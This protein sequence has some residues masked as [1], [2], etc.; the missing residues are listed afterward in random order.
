MKSTSDTP[1]TNEQMLYVNNP[2]GRDFRVVSVSF[3]RELETELVAMTKERDEFRAECDGMANLIWEHPTAPCDQDSTLKSITRVEV[4][5]K[6]CDAL[7]A[8][9]KIK[10][11]AL[12]FAT[13]RHLD[14]LVLIG[15]LRSE[16]ASLKGNASVALFNSERTYKDALRS[17]LA[18]FQQP[19]HQEQD[20]T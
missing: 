2:H 10:L 6:E 3:A 7:R 16:L 14:Q 20:I 8:E 19:T 4:L 9:L 17:E 13:G 12:T 18:Q 1:R 15:K 5:R 11:E